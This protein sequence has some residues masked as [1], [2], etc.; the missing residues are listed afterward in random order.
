MTTGASSFVGF[1][2]HCW[3]DVVPPRTLEVYKAYE[4]VTT[5]KGNV[6]L[7][8]VD[9]FGSVFPTA[10]LPVHEAIEENARSCGIHAWEAKPAISRLLG[11]MRE[12][13]RP[14][15]YSTQ[16]SLS[17]RGA[18]HRTSAGPSG[19][20]GRVDPADFEIAKEFTPQR[21]DVVIRKTRASVFFETTLLHELSNRA[22]DTLVLC[23]ETTSGCVRATAVDAYSHGLHVVVIEDAV[24]DRSLLSHQ[25]SLFDLHHKYADVMNLDEFERIF[26]GA[27]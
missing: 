24:F 8:A 3:K 2:D 21:G 23:G 27:M 19:S 15:I 18:T 22:T 9:L 5:V 16:E 13:N 4:R 1:E 14:V 20:R 25:V 12:T 6:T 7:L 11:V 17:N 10:P 26:I